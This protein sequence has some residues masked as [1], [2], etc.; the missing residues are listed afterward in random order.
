MIRTIAAAT[1]G[2]WAATAVVIRGG[3][4]DSYEGW[5]AVSGFDQD[6]GDLVVVGDG[7]AGEGRGG[8]AGPAPIRSRPRFSVVVHRRGRPD[9]VGDISPH[10]ATAL[11]VKHAQMHSIRS[12]L[13]VEHVPA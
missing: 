1:A 2:S 6:H 4:L 9:S 3:P 10:S 13:V 12:F 8:M 11:A 7:A 5:C